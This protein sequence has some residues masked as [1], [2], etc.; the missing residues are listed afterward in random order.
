MM[1]LQDQ[2][3]KSCKKL[4][5]PYKERGNNLDKCLSSYLK[6]IYQRPIKYPM[7]YPDLF[8]KWGSNCKIAFDVLVFHHD[9]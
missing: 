7:K 2:A 6:I 8:I 1:G 9:F 3:F 5:P 4:M